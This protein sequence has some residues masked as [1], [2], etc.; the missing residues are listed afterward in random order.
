MVNVAIKIA[1]ATIADAELLSHLSKI[2]FKDTFQGT[3]TEEDMQGFIDNTLSYEV[4][5]EELKDTADVLIGSEDS[6]LGTGMLYTKALPSILATSNSNDDIHD[7]FLVDRQAEFSGAKG[8]V[9]SRLAVTN[10]L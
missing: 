2:T 3:C 9:I 4:I 5:I 1:R 6:T 8:H 7:K 10:L